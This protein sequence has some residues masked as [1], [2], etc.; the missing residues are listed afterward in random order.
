MQDSVV[1]TKL[2]CAGALL[3]GA[4]GGASTFPLADEFR[5]YSVLDPGTNLDTETQ[6]ENYSVLVQVT[7][8]SFGADMTPY[9]QQR[10]QQGYFG[11]LTEFIFIADPE[12]RI[13]GWTG[14]STLKFEGYDNIY[15]DSSGVV[16][17]QK[18]RGIMRAVWSE[19]LVNYAFKR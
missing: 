19:R 11:R 3:S 9:W 6:A 18:S 10:R 5:T 1:M 12:D 4:R 8:S 7:T 17:S 16:P 13:V 2:P 15:I 14:Y